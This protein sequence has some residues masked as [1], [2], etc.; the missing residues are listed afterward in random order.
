MLGFLL[1]SLWSRAARLHA[2]SSITTTGT[3]SHGRRQS[4]SSI[5]HQN[6]DRC[7]WYEGTASQRYRTGL[8]VQVFL[9]DAETTPIVSM[10]VTQS[11]LLS[12]ETYLVDRLDNKTRENMRHLKCICFLR[13]SGDSIQDLIEELRDPRYG[14]YHLCRSAYCE[15]LAD[16]IQTLAMRS[17]SRQ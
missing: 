15:D 5:C 17:K 14:D 2:A 13:P 1:H 9:L 4:C 8:I 6:A 10:A 16:N 11:Q 7:V 3:I 12:H